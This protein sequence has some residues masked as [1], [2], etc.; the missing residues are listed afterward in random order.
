ML[1]IFI[2]SYLAVL[3]GCGVV[4]KWTGVMRPLLAIGLP[5]LAL[6]GLCNWCCR[7]SIRRTLSGEAWPHRNHRVWG[8]CHLWI[9]WL[10][11]CPAI[12]QTA[13]CRRQWEREEMHGGWWGAWLNDW[14]SA[15]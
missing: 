6:D 8:W 7:Q 4:Y 14:R 12:G 1:T 11:A 3:A 2:G 13:H 5:A 10:F 15:A 9:D